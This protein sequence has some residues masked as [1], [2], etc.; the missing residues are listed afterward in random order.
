MQIEP[1]A[2]TTVSVPRPLGAVILKAAAFLADGREPARHLEDAAMLLAC[3]EDPFA[4]REVLAGSDRKRLLVL[5]RA[6]ADDH[7]AWLRLPEPLRRDG[8]AALDVLC[9][10]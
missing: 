3:I 7:V 1:G 10:P 4:E 5:Q 2:A 8:R 9:Q 6:L